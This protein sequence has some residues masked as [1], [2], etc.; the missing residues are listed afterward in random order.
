M[1]DN[2]MLLAT[3]MGL[4]RH[5]HYLNGTSVYVKIQ[6]IFRCSYSQQ[7]REK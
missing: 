2:Q 7:S 6:S 1:T 4:N 3:P 5:H